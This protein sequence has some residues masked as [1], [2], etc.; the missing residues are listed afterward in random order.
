MAGL[1]VLSLGPGAV[2]SAQGTNDAP[3]DSGTPGALDAPEA[4]NCRRIEPEYSRWLDQGNSPES[5]KFAG[6]TYRDVG[7]GKLY[8]WLDWLDWADRAG[9]LG[10]IERSTGAQ[11]TLLVGGAI[12][13]FGAAL[14]G[15]QG[16]AGPK[17][18]G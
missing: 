2:G 11:T 16:G 6:K 7:T 18:P 13:A 1:A 14:I 12:T 3:I 8:S 9:C 10:G 4:W 5:W 15:A 17:S